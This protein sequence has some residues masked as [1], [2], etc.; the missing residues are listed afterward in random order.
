MFFCCFVTDLPIQTSIIIFFSLPLNPFTD[1]YH[2]V[3]IIKRQNGWTT[4]GGGVGA[5]EAQPLYDMGL[6]YSTIQDAGLHRGQGGQLGSDWTI[7]VISLLFSFR[8]KLLF[9]MNTFIWTT[10]KLTLDCKHFCLVKSDHTNMFIINFRYAEEIQCISELRRTLKCVDLCK[11]DTFQ[12]AVGQATGKV[13]LVNMAGG[14]KNFFGGD[15]CEYIP[16]Q[17]HCCTAVSWHPS[18]YSF[19]AAGFEKLR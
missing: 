2:I 7:Q 4:G 14:T 3:V 8:V 10:S 15:G 19:L 6:W 16:R 12:L 5:A 9:M 17:S 1:G 18:N 13:S 11:G